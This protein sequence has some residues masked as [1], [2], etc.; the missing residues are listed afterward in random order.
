MKKN[1]ILLIIC[2][3]VSI[4]VHAADFIIINKIMYDSPLNEQIAQSIPYSNGEYIEL[5]NAGIS[6]ADMT[7]WT[8]RGG[9]TTET[10]NFPDNTI[11]A[12]KSFLIIA[13]QYY[14]SGFTVD[15]LYS[16]LYP[17]GNNQILYQ[18]K[19]ILSNSGE[20][21]YLKDNQ[22]V[23]RDSIYYDG[24]SNKTKPNRLSADNVD[25]LSG[26]SCMCLQ[27]KTAL[28][29]DTGCA[30]PDNLEWITALVNPFQLHISFITPVLP[31]LG[32]GYYYD[33]AGNRVSRG[34]INLSRSVS[35]V[36]SNNNE[37]TPAIHEEVGKH[38]IT[39]YPNP[40]KGQ[41][42]LYIDGYD[43]NTAAEIRIYESSGKLIINRKVDAPT[44]DF[45][46]SAKAQGVYFLRIRINDDLL[47]YKIIKE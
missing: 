35:Y 25:G 6:S 41:L 17:S 39:I 9:G 37:E 30:I 13:Y 16:G 27:R 23:V 12:P 42:S 36:K 8:L 45:D 34:I 11:I 22:S 10:Y 33:L 2:F 40:T 44:A 38:N 21:V 7:G 24:T 46:L 15:Q 31:G 4:V 43:E 1:Y 19:I 28:F 3:F 14:N 29:T 26:N 20:P 32:L 18:R 47:T 5:Y